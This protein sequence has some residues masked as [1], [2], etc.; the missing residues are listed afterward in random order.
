MK[1]ILIYILVVVLALIVV[2]TSLIGMINYSHSRLKPDNLKHNITE[3]SITIVDAPIAAKVTAIYKSTHTVIAYTV[4]TIGFTIVIATYSVC[5][6]DI[7]HF[8]DEDNIIYF[9]ASDAQQLVHKTLNLKHK[10]DIKCY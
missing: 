7:T 1:Q 9:C 2:I 10:E 3:G 5:I 6:D 4:D 8:N